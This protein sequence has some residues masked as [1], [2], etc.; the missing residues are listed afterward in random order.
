VLADLI[1]IFNLD[2][3]TTDLKS[4]LLKFGIANS[5]QP[6]KTERSSDAPFF[7]SCNPVVCVPT[8]NMLIPQT[9]G[10]DTNSGVAPLLVS[11]PTILKT[12]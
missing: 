6:K 3:K 7:I 4:D 12:N 5:K 10:E 8:N 1:Q 2:G 9:V 11:S